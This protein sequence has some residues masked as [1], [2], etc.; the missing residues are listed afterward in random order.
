MVVQEFC[1]KQEEFAAVGEVDIQAKIN[2][3]SRANLDAITVR[4][5]CGCD[6]IPVIP[7]TV[8]DI[9]IVFL[10]D[11]SDSFSNTKMQRG[12]SIIA[13][14]SGHKVQLPWFNEIVNWVGDVMRSIDAKI[15]DIN[16]R[17]TF[18]LV[19]FS[20]LRQLESRYIPDSDGRAIP[21]NDDL[22]HYKF[23]LNSPRKY[24]GAWDS[25]DEDLAQVDGLDSN[26]Q[27]FLALQDLTSEKFTDQLK[28]LV[29]P[30]KYHE[31]KRILV[32]ITDEEWD[33]SNLKQGARFRSTSSFDVLESDPIDRSHREKVA[34]MAHDVFD[35][36]MSIIVRQNKT[37]ASINEDFIVKQLSKGNSLDYIKVYTED[38]AEDMDVARKRIVRNIMR[39]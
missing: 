33:V 10:I 6:E 18:T 22:W 21:G 3:A 36:M 20:G 14:E 39:L 35:I 25:M 24:E 7:D 5:A 16:D 26:S 31:R 8:N 38:F 32:T 19:Q 34:E 11:S 17:C 37:Q 12:G 27:L 23:E 29:P 4:H 30:R 1:I 15:P 2:I 13:E 28:A 9:D